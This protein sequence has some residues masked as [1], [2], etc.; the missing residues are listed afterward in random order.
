MKLYTRSGD[1]G[2]T[3]L[4]GGQRV[5]KDHPRIA[6]YG[7]VDELNAALGLAAAELSR[8]LHSSAKPRL[9]SDEGA[10]KSGVPAP[11]PGG[12]VLVLMDSI[13][14]E[15]QSRLFDIGADLA[16]PPGTA[17]ESKISR[18]TSRHVAEAERW[19]DEIDSG[20]EPMRQFVLP[21]GTELAAR[22]HQARTIS[23]RAERLMVSLSRSDQV[24]PEAIIYLNRV[25]DLLFAMARRANQ[26]AGVP[27]VPWTPGAR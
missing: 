8:V 7:T 20:N 17:H 27:D 14:R 2:T 22:L 21:G 3:G 26:H 19:I 24:T 25:S 4:F 15:L 13:L 11:T 9:T 23:R 16:T 10:R 5:G 1:D 6:A 12:D 18:V